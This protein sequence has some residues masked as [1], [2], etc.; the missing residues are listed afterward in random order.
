MALLKFLKR[1]KNKTQSTSAGKNV[2]SAKRPSSSDI[3][4]D[5]I[6]P[7][8]MEVVI[9][10]STN[11]AF[12]EAW[13]QHWAGLDESEKVAWSFQGNDSPLKVQETTEDLDQQHRQETA[14]RRVAPSTLRFLKAI[15]TVMA[16]ATI[17][18]QAYPDVSSIVMGIIRVVINVCISL[19]YLY[20]YSPA[21]T[22]IGRSQILRIL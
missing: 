6:G 9:A 11:P 10:K 4:P 21:D 7:D 3:G 17:G 5:Q 22:E 14:S 8:Q 13:K 19:C 12:Q 16:G 2:T 18:I 1:K 15:E 20:S